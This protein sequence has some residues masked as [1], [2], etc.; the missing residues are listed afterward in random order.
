MLE[1]HKKGGKICK[2]KAEGGQVKETSVVDSLR[3]NPGLWR[4]V[5]GAEAR[6]DLSV[7]SCTR[8]QGKGDESLLNPGAGQV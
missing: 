3:G 4:Q 8:P 1:R 7:I 2:A 5:A 6:C